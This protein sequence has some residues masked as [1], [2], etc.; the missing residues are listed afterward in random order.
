MITNN[1]LQEQIHELDQKI[2]M[3]GLECGWDDGTGT[4]D[5]LSRLVNGS[6]STLEQKRA[7]NCPIQQEL[8]L[9]QLMHKRS[10][11]IRR[12]EKNKK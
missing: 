3:A 8:N 10:H 1:I 4:F 5:I 11:L 7:N 9:L 6:A 12:L 2:T